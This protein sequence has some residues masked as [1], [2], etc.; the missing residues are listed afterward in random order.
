MRGNPRQNPS[1]KI[2]DF[3][4]SRVVEKSVNSVFA[5]GRKAPFTTLLLLSPP[6]PPDGWASAGPRLGEAFVGAYFSLP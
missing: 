5:L 4:T 6:N 2:R 1:G 3:A